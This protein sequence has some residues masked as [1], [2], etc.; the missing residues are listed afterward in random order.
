MIAQK[1]EP[2]IHITNMADRQIVLGRVTSELIGF[3]LMAN[4][5]YA[6]SHWSIAYAHLLTDTSNVYKHRWLEVSKPVSETK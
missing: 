6:I 5:Y 1:I 2:T 4:T 3:L